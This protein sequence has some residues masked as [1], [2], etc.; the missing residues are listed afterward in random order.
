MGQAILSPATVET[1]DKIA[2]PT[3]PTILFLARLSAAGSTL[4]LATT[5]ITTQDV[6][7]SPSCGRAASLPAHLRV[8]SKGSLEI[9]AWSRRG[10]GRS[11]SRGM[12]RGER[13]RGP[14]PVAPTCCL[15][16]HA[17]RDLHG[18]PWRAS[19]RSAI[20]RTPDHVLSDDRRWRRPRRSLRRAGRAQRVYRIQ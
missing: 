5:T 2:R 20:A 16:G 17:I 18:L 3:L 10:C 7:V 11:G 9:R 12:R 8:A 15:P 4:L 1:G 19:L 14:I 6:A 13:G